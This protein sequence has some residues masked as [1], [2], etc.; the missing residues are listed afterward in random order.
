MAVQ[1]PS[2]KMQMAISLQQI[3]RFTPCL[4]LG[5]VFGVNGSNSAISGLT[6]SKMAAQP[7]SWKTNM[8][9]CSRWII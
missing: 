7:P 3:I 6:K 9:I 4:V 5:G 2:W 8:L 1:P